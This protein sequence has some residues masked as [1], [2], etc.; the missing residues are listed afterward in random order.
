MKYLLRFAA[1]LLLATLAMADSNARIVRVSYVEG[2]VRMD[3]GNGEGMVTAFSN[4]PVVEGASFVDGNDG[5]AEIEFEDHTTLRLTQ[6]G[7]LTFQQLRI[8]DNGRHLTTASLDDGE[9]YLHVN[10]HSKDEYRIEV[11][12]ASVI[13]RHGD[14]VRIWLDRNEARIA[15]LSGTVEVDRGEGEH[16]DVKKHETLS[17]DFSD[18]SRYF[19]AKG[20][21]EEYNDQWNKDRDKEIQLASA[22][23]NR[24]YDAYRSYGYSGYDTYASDLYQYGNFIPVSNYGMMWQP[25]GCTPTWD[26]F[27]SGQWIWYPTS[28]YV[29]VSPYSW[30]WTPYHSGRWIFVNGYGWMWQPPGSRSGWSTFRPQPTIVNAPPS[31]TVRPPQQHTGDVVPVSAGYHPPSRNPRTSGWRPTDYASGS[32]VASRRYGAGFNATNAPNATSG[33]AATSARTGGTSVASGESKTT[34]GTA[35]VVS[36]PTSVTPSAVA[37]ARPSGPAEQTRFRP[38]RPV[39]NDYSP[40]RDESDTRNG[41]PD[42]SVTTSRDA[43][44]SNP[45]PAP[46]ERS[47]SSERPSYRP[48]ES[49]SSR[50]V[51]R[52]PDRPSYSPPP[53]P[54][55][56]YSPPTPAPPPPPP[57]S[58]SPRGH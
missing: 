39:R 57:S 8:L 52:Q 2:D 51:E 26:P 36:S 46:R 11:K 48:S 24:S 40:S 53:A 4:M 32:S 21:S 35:G 28:G 13:A 15:V 27:S 38:E 19:L 42:G 31:L 44:Q 30:G 45:R 14:D 55:R 43:G 16:L 10:G 49:P 33:T 54:T 18:P 3:R 23:R 58:R 22:R 41:S 25:Y 1:P 47:S 34:A 6:S 12:R 7:A 5:R 9:I 29:F 37:A 56:I 17:L 20:I 50:P